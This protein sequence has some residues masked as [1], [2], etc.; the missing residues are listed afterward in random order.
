MFV[1]LD[2]PA[3]VL[4]PDA[5]YSY[6]G[7]GTCIDRLLSDHVS[8]GLGARYL[9]LLGVGISQSMNPATVSG[10]RLGKTGKDSHI[11]PDLRQDGSPDVVVFVDEDGN[12]VGMYVTP[13]GIC[14]DEC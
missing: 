12:C 10:F 5:S 14:T 6:V 2:R 1:L 4:I 3:S 7:S 11:P 8:S 13:P 9:Y